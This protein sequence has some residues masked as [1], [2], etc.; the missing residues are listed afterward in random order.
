VERRGRFYFALTPTR[1]PMALAGA[2]MNLIVGTPFNRFREKR[3]DRD[4]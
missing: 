3:A 1:T 2:G 4:R